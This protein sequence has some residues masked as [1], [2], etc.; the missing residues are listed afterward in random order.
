I[1]DSIC[2]GVPCSQRSPIP[3]PAEAAAE[4]APAAAA[5]AAPA[6]PLGAL[7]A[8][9]EALFASLPAAF[10]LFLFCRYCLA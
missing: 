8:E 10:H 5:A 4:S 7:G 9:T 6:Q 3:S 2:A 1:A